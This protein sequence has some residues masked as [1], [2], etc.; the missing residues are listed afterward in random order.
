MLCQLCHGQEQR[1][2]S[3]P[4][5]LYPKYPPV[6]IGICYK[7]IGMNLPGS[8][9]GFWSELDNPKSK[10]VKKNDSP[11]YPLFAVVILL[12]F[13]LSKI[14]PH[15]RFLF[16]EREPYL[17]MEDLHVAWVEWPCPPRLRAQ[18]H[19]NPSSPLATRTSL[20]WDGYETQLVPMR[21]IPPTWGKHARSE[22]W[23]LSCEVER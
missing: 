22:A 7:E 8:P 13:C 6:S 9:R 4:I 16:Q 3:S 11:G 1:W 17:S 15:P 14:L 20:L 10:E 19:G 23:L 12:C 21:M 18:K 5:M 2:T